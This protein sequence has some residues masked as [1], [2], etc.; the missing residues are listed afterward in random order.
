MN[1]NEAPSVSLSPVRPFK[2][3]FIRPLLCRTKCRGVS[4]LLRLLLNGEKMSN[5][6]Y[7]V[8]INRGKLIVCRCF[9]SSWSTTVCLCPPADRRSIPTLRVTH[10]NC[11]PWSFLPSGQLNFLALELF[12][13][14][15]PSWLINT[16]AYRILQPLNLE[17]LSFFI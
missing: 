11:Q 6:L 10:H 12:R 13:Q 8:N 14:W 17:V 9:L 5:S 4:S 1:Q 7:E 2:C 15:Q 16:Q 3:Q